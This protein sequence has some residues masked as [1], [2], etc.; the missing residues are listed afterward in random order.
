M[1]KQIKLLKKKLFLR[2]RLERF[3]LSEISLIKYIVFVDLTFKNSELEHFK[4]IF[5]KYSILVLLT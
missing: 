2:I 5:I 4:L 3:D 1:Q